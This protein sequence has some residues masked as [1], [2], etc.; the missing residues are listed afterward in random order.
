MKKLKLLKGHT[1]GALSIYDTQRKKYPPNGVF[2]QLTLLYWK[3]I[4]GDP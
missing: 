2:F 3:E 1:S 4:I